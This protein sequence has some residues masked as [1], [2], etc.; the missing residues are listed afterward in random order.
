LTAFAQENPSSA[1]SADENCNVAVVSG[2][3]E[4]A[5]SSGQ[6]GTQDGAARGN[7]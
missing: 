7:Q 3:G 5:E 1:D 6:T 4:P 2:G